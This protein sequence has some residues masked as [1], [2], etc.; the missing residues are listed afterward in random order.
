MGNGGRQVMRF[1]EVPSA[2]ES[3][4]HGG[5]CTP[6]RPVGGVVAAGTGGRNPGAMVV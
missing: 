3:P 4:K 1:A 6:R 5:Y 2:L